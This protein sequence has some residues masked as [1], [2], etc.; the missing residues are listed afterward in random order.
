MTTTQAG[1]TPIWVEPNDPL[2]DPM[3]LDTGLPADTAIAATDNS[4]S[5]DWPA[6]L[7]AAG[8]DLSAERLTEAYSK[9]L[10]PWFSEGQP[11]LWWSPDPRMVLKI[12]DF[13]LHRSLVKTLR[14][15]RRAANYRIT[16]NQAF[17]AVIDACASPR[18]QQ[19]GTW[20]TDDMRQAYINLH[21]GG[22]AHSVEVW[23]LEPGS[24]EHLIGG[25]YGVSI[26]RMF[27][28]ESMFARKRDASKIALA[29]LVGLLK[30]HDIPMIDCQQ[31]TGHL[32]SL[33]AQEIARKEFLG[34]TSVLTIQPPPD[35]SSMS[36]HFP[37]V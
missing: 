23:E 5:G 16:L 12:K 3:H 27:F 36:I 4:N 11:V 6:G 29:S 31:N 37:A 19:S 20:I 10:F 26:G 22:G 7:I 2:P 30:K 24:G 17:S 18:D 13:R 8:N 25:L 1:C 34:Q 35:W 21:A 9:G 28:G 32:A 15:W 14:Q 33:G